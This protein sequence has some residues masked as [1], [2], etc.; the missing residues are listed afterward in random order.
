MQLSPPS[1]PS[2]PSSPLTGVPRS[3]RWGSTTSPPPWCLAGLAKVQRAVCLLSNTA[4]IAEAWARLDQ[5]DLM[6]AGRAF[7]YWYVG[8]GM[9][10]GESSEAREDMAALEKDYEEVGMDSLEAEG[11]RLRK[12]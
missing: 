3:S 12:G 2:E 9:E 5:F 1:R 10:E 8:E 4:A 7:A 6:Y 11:E